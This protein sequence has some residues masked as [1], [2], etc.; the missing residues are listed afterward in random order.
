[1]S[2]D[3]KERQWDWVMECEQGGA[4]K[5]WALIS[6]QIFNPITFALNDKFLRDVSLKLFGNCSLCADRHFGYETKT[7]AFLHCL[8]PWFKE[9]TSELITCNQKICLGSQFKKEGCESYFLWWPNWELK[10]TT[11]DW[12]LSSLVP[13]KMSTLLNV[14]Y[15]PPKCAKLSWVL[16]F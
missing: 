15:L 7:L 9:K 16:Q 8:R 1:M 14:K 11:S 4:E 12:H 10:A 3:G 13:F 2:E 6:V 5:F